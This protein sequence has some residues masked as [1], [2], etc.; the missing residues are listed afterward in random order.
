M[1][2]IILKDNGVRH[3]HH[4]EGVDDDGDSPAELVKVLGALWKSSREGHLMVVV[5]YDNVVVTRIVECS[6][7]EAAGGLA[8]HDD[9][10][11]CLKQQM[12][13]VERDF[14]IIRNSVRI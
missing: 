10:E 6:I 14:G 8:N 5:S 12:N 3:L 1:T 9:G 4:V 13:K 2:Y 11:G 7:L